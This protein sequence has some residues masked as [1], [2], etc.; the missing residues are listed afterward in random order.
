VRARARRRRRRRDDDL[1]RLY[2]TRPSQRQHRAAID[3]PRLEPDPGIADSCAA[4][5]APRHRRFEVVLEDRRC[6]GARRV[7]ITTGLHDDIPDIPG[8][9]SGGAAACST[10]RTATA[11]RSG[12][13][14][15]RARRPPG[16]RGARPPGPTSGPTTSSTSATAPRSR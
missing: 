6:L 5:A 12:T 3:A 8:C 7:L 1:P 13:S 9:T 11:T 16:G 14:P 4:S 10:A 2:A 15:W